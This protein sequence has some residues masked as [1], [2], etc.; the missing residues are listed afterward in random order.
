MK[1]TSIYLVV[2]IMLMALSGIGAWAQATLT[3]VNGRV[4]DGGK[5]VADAQV[6]FTNLNTGKQFKTKTDKNGSY[7]LVGLERTGYQIEVMNA[8]GEKVYSAKE[9]ITGEASGAGSAMGGE[10]TM[11]IDLSQMSGKGQPKYSK[12]QIEEIKKQNAKAEGQNALINQA[13]AAMNAKNWEGAI[14][15]LQQL[16]QSDPNRWQFF[17]ALGNAQLNTQQYDQAVESYEKG[18]QVTQ[19][20]VAGNIKDPKNPDSDPVKAKTGMA[21]MLQNEGNAYLKLNKKDQALAA[22][23]KAASMD[24]NPGTAYFNICATQYN[25]GN[26]DAAE[27]AC[28]KAIAADPNKAEA[29]FIKGSAMFGKGKMDAN[30]K[31]TVPQGTAEALNK[32][33]QLAPD[34]AHANDVKQ[35]LESVGAKIETT[36]KAKKK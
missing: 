21:Q 4:S 2:G 19:N 10:Q 11:N 22:F 17:Q 29:Y 14:P 13:M 32:Y 18:I 6:V 15:P 28:D 30:N 3:R 27:A 34:G 25:T 9:N 8:A 5:P 12:E 16:T 35:M 36:Y 33:L 24:P 23:E 7:N 1:K 31:W 20:V 26:M